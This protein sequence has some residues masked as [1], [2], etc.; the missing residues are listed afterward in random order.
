MGV[1]IRCFLNGD[2][3]KKVGG[4]AVFHECFSM[5]IMAIHSNCKLDL[6]NVYFGW[7]LQSNIFLIRLGLGYSG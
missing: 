4:T 5:I 1:L 6:G 2:H 3:G 7:L